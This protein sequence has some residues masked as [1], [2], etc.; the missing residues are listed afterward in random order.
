MKVLSSV[1]VVE[2]GGIGPGPFCAMHLADLGADVV[3]V[4][5]PLPGQAPDPGRTLLNRGKRSVTADL[6][7]PQGRDAVLQTA[8]APRFDGAAYAPGVMAADGEHTEAV[9]AHIGA[10]DASTVWRG[11]R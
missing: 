4:V 10:A 3:S 11:A 2:I 1:R 8:P 5:R 6:K 9:M 7:S